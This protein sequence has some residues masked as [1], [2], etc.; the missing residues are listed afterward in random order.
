MRQ[1][2]TNP[3]ALSSETFF[4]LSFCSLSLSDFDWETFKEAYDDV[5]SG[6]FDK[7]YRNDSKYDKQI[8]EGLKY[9]KKAHAYFQK[10][11]QKGSVRERWGKES[12]RVG[13]RRQFE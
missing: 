10:Y 8:E 11:A 7:Q 13:E 4:F 12:G 6:L 5:M 9:L 1:Q 2:I 3:F